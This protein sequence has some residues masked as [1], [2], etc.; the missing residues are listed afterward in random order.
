MENASV[1]GNSD[2]GQLFPNREEK[3]EGRG[4]RKEGTGEPKKEVRLLFLL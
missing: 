2:A 3:E 4:G 1:L